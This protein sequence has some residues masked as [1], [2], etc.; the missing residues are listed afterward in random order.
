M[1]D[2]VFVHIGVPK[3]GTTYLQSILWSNQ[4]S[5]AHN[6]VLVPGRYPYDHNRVVQ[7][8]RWKAPDDQAKEAWRY[9]MDEIH[10][11]PGTAILSNEWFC[12]ANAKQIRRLV[13]ALD[14]REVH[15][16]VTARRLTDVI[17][18]A[19]QENLK[20]GAAK[21]F[22]DFVETLD[23]SGR[24]RWRWSALD[25]AEFLPRWQE[26]VTPGHVHVITLQTGHKNAELLWTRFASLIA[27]EN[28]H[29]IDFPE[30]G[31]N[32][33]MSAESA[34]LLELV[35]GQLREAIGAPENHWNFPYRWI[36]DYLSHELLAEV[37]GS[38]IGVP[39]KEADIVRRRA[40]DST[41]HLKSGGYDI[42]GDLSELFVDQPTAS[43]AVLPSD[44]PDAA[45]IDL[46]GRVMALMLVRIQRESERASRSERKLKQA[47]RRL[48]EAERSLEVL[49]PISRRLSLWRA[50]VPA[51]W[52][53]SH[54]Q[55]KG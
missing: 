13:E 3:S 39:P 18:S 47:E 35:G 31:E 53:R 6:G 49:A 7:T 14:A 8:L 46:A 48:D 22:S 17:P 4:Q 51:S 29:A 25:P 41:A 21:S 40:V 27:L 34:R 15:F 55:Q 37:S 43:G 12:M 19:W 52:A 38:K 44:V 24:Q 50:F 5:L 32:R 45:V 20:L 28:D 33:S 1:A 9:V 11:W 54:S 2:K 30:A 42:V 10:A 26:A 23:S 16:V 36:R